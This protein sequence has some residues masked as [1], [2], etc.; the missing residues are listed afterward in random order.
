[1]GSYPITTGTFGTANARGGYFI[2]KLTSNLASTYFTTHLGNT[3]AS[4]FS[5][6]NYPTAFQV[7][8]CAN[9]Y[10]SAYAIPSCPVTPNAYEPK[11]RSLYLCHLSEEANRLIYGSYFGSSPSNSLHQHPA[12][13]STITEKGTLHHIECTTFN[14]YPFT[15]GA[16]SNRKTGTND[17][18]IFKFQF[19]APTGSLLKARFESPGIACAPHT[20]KF[21]N[22]STNALTYTWDFADGTPQTTEEDPVHTFQKPGK[23]RVRLV[24]ANPNSCSLT[25]TAYAEVTVKALAVAALPKEPIYLCEKTITADAGNPGSIFN[26]STGATTQT[27]DIT[28]PGVYR[29][30]ISNG[31]CSLQDSITVVQPLVPQTPNI[32][33]PNNDGK[34]DN[35]TILNKGLNTKLEI[36]N[37]WG[38][39]VYKTDDYKNDW[40]GQQESAGTY[41]YTIETPAACNQVTKGW[42]EIIR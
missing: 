41:F 14:D 20:I 17:G 33:T 40:D 11:I 2:H 27:I 18:A 36:Y 1:V 21:N 30:E 12:N 8:D 39:L 15:P 23:Y 9:I 5:S 19:D 26:W 37:R 13:H 16:Y 38:R 7:D 4:G 42:L 10:F 28:Q 29:V 35:F 31:S 32:I 6:E 25:D 34:N 24:A 3:N 22:F